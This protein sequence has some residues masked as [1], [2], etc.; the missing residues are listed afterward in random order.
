MKEKKDKGLII[1]I[2]I[3]IIYGLLMLL[4]GLFLIGFVA[5]D[6]FDNRDY[7]IQ[8]DGSI[9]DDDIIIKKDV[10][11]YYD[12]ATKTYYIEGYLVN[13]DDESLDYVYLEY[14]VYDKDG[15][16]LG[17]AMADIDTL[18]PKATW[19]F[20]ARYDDIDA[21]SVSSFKIADID[22]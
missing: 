6:I 17:S 8:N 16:I 11:G 20:K 18:A 7:K 1:V 2:V 22:Y 15:N 14:T 3:S 4:P 12:D 10:K 21:A 13:K 9:K 19:K 5:F